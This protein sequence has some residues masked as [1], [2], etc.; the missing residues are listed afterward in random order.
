MNLAS[1]D[2]FYY[3]QQEDNFLFDFVPQSS[4]LSVHTSHTS[5]I[6]YRGVSTLENYLPLNQQYNYS[7]V[8]VIYNENSG[9]S[10]RIAR[11][12]QDVRSIPER[13]MCNITTSTS[14]TV[15][16][17]EFENIRDQIEEYLE[18]HNLTNE[19]NY[20]VTTK[21]VPLRVSGSSW[22]NACL[23]SELTM[24]LG[25]Y[26]TEIGNAN[27]VLNPY[28]QDN[29]PFSRSKYDIFLV[30][31][32]TAYTE[33]EIYNIIDNATTSLTNRGTYV[34]DADASKGWQPSGYGIGNVWLRDADSKLR[35][36]GEITYYDY[37]NT[38]V[39]SYSNVMGYSSWGSNDGYDTANFINNWN[40]ESV[41]NDLPNNWHTIL[42]PGI[43][44]NISSNSSDKLSG[45]YSV[46]I[47]RTSTSQNSSAFVQNITITQGMRY[48][49][50]GNINLS[51]ITGP[52]GA[53]FQIQALDINNKIL[54]VQ[55]SQV[56]S[57]VTSSWRGLGQ[58]IYEPVPGAVKVRILA[59][60]NR[61]AGIV[62]FDDIRFYDIPP[63]FSWLPGSIAETFVSTG[64]RS[65]TYGTSYGQSLVAD[66]IRDGVTGVKGYV[67]E[68]F[69]DAIAHP[70]I[71]FDR[72]TDGYNLAE[73]YYMASNYI[74]WMDVIVGDP[75]MAPYGDIL[76]D[77]NVSIYGLNYNPD[78]PN[79]NDWL[80]V[81]ANISNVGTVDVSNIEVSLFLVTNED[82]I[83]IG[84]ELIES[85]SKNG[86]SKEI[87]ILY[88]LTLGGNAAIKII[89]DPG[90]MIKEADEFNNFAE[91][92]IYIN[93]PP[94]PFELVCDQD[95]LL[96]GQEIVVNANGS[97]IETIKMNLQPVLEAKL[98]PIGTWFNFEESQISYQYI[99]AV[100]NWQITVKTDK[101]MK[102]GNYSLRISF[103]D[104]QNFTGSYYQLYRALE[105]LNN[106]PTI[107]LFKTEQTIINRTKSLIISCKPSD[108]EDPIEKLKISIQ[109]RLK[110]IDL[111]SNLGWEN[112]DDIEF[113]DTLNLWF[114][115]LNFEM[116]AKL[117][118]YQIRGRTIDLDS[119]ASNWSYIVHDILLMNNIPLL[120]ELKLST[121]RI[122]RTESVDI[123]ITGDDAENN[124]EL[125]KLLC[126]IEYSIN[127]EPENKNQ[128]QTWED[129]YLT[130]VEYDFFEDAWVSRFT[131]PDSSR[132]GLYFFRARLQDMDGN[133]SDWFMSKHIVN[134]LNNPP[135]A[136]MD[137][138]ATEII[139]DTSVE[140]KASGSRDL[141]DGIENL[142]F[143][144]ELSGTNRFSKS[145]FNFTY[146]FTRQG[147]YNISLKVTDLDGKS[148][149]ENKTIIVENVRPVARVKTSKLKAATDE[150]IEF[151]ATE[152][153][154]TPS[155]I[156]TLKYTWDFGDGQK[157]T[158]VK[159]NY[160]YSEPGIYNVVLTVLDDNNATDLVQV[161]IRI[162]LAEI[163]ENDQSDNDEEVDFT[164]LLIANC[165]VITI[166]F[167]LLILL[168]FIRRKRR[169]MLESKLQEPY[170][171]RSE[172]E[173]IDQNL[174]QPSEFIQPENQK[175]NSLKPIKLSEI[176]QQLPRPG[177]GPY[178]RP[179]LPPVTLSSVS[180]EPIIEPMLEPRDEGIP[181]TNLEPEQK[182]N[183][184]Y[185]EE[186]RNEIKQ[187]INDPEDDND[188]SENAPDV[189][190]HL[191][192]DSIEDFDINND[193][194]NEEDV[195][196]ILKDLMIK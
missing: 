88:K 44:D 26:S 164:T 8:L 106:K 194:D 185:L 160:S 195:E 83:L 43:I 95:R 13:N 152:S 75:K 179:T 2:I 108:F 103:I 187:N 38:F 80:T 31:R 86:G 177:L 153:F 181:E 123:S 16:R 84:N 41:S 128:S 98:E 183:E 171:L 24:I 172:A 52:G 82:E 58:L 45:I 182:E 6:H 67:Y 90:Q 53:H 122:N 173:H 96:R 132:V 145:G 36:K 49:L 105:I 101:T 81:R 71:L 116:D 25:Q 35:A 133:W 169:A 55:N 22:T 62:F 110:P 140:F 89:V 144:W 109:F 147:A 166:I 4:N 42:D 191:D 155:D 70:D 178:E 78:I 117:G 63:H 190:D 65:F 141:E 131:P 157:G 174:D 12:F 60:L 19:I 73:S 124:F 33:A 111:S 72:Y 76:P 188:R 136:V 115:A 18:N 142:D 66:L 156:D 99:P 163:L 168:I 92:L 102:I 125:D 162:T 154:D 30:T 186:N 39:K 7:D 93:N 69:L 74:G 61:S 87:E 126:V 34:L 47:N 193:D 94:T 112:I 28:Y 1:G 192:D 135:N 79:S 189:N 27:R 130:E 151:S 149:W 5:N 20:L 180:P 21:G 129:R 143:Q 165:I 150:N 146:I 9:I 104:E 100:D 56:W 91:K 37:N 119:G 57:S 137:K 3:Q 77:M 68:P 120:Y 138:I 50:T 32:L 46:L 107:E 59:E 14:E 85:I 167:V 139:E 196:K 51:A 134:V 15:N 148:A 29:E 127:D 121:L 161:V 114:C 48:Y 158:G 118:T 97:D 40:L 10:T 64:G 54:K 159:I 23:D 176:P 17:N 113:N 170:I 184:V 175:Y 11:Y